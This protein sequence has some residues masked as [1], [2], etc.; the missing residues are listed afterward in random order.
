MIEALMV[1]HLIH[2]F[3][4]FHL[5]DVFVGVS[6]SHIWIF[7]ANLGKQYFQ[8]L[9]QEHP[10]LCGAFELHYFEVYTGV[11]ETVDAVNLCPTLQMA[12]PSDPSEQLKI[13]AGFQEK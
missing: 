12:F 11:W 2:D 4:Q 7:L 9:H 1:V 10:R 3:F 13:A 6:V 5:S 8:H